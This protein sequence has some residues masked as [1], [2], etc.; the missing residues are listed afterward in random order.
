MQPCVP[1][2]FLSLL[3]RDLSPG[4][5][6]QFSSSH[7]TEPNDLETILTKGLAMNVKLEFIHT[8][9]NLSYWFYVNLKAFLT[10]LW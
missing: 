10:I 7:L 6:D 2:R 4:F 1:F 9:K 3:Q 8:I 5:L